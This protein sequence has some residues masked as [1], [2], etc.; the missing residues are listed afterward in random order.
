MSSLVCD[1]LNI[2]VLAD[3][4]GRIEPAAAWTLGERSRAAVAG[5]GLGAMAER[6]AARYAAL[7]PP[8]V[9]TA[10]RQPPRRYVSG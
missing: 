10:R 9:W 8:P 6:L 7:A 3:R 4:M 2:V 5:L 1:P